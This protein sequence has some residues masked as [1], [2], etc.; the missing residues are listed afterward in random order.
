MLVK[1]KISFTGAITMIAGELKEV[2]E[3]AVLDDL[4]KCGYVESAE[5]KQPTKKAVSGNENKRTARQ[6]N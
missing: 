4:L 2:K 1:A 3:G 6:R 5:K